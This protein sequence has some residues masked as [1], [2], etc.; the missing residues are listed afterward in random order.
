MKTIFL[1][2]LGVALLAYFRVD[3]RQIVTKVGQSIA[4]FVQG[5]TD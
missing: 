2:I 5:L 4:P 1:I 3:L